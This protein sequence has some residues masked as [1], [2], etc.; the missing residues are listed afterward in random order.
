MSFPAQPAATQAC[1]CAQ[2]T[3]RTGPSCFL[4]QV[5]VLKVQGSSKDRDWSLTP[6]RGR[7]PSHL[8]DQPSAPHG[9]PLATYPLQQY[10]QQHPAD[11]N[12]LSVLPR[13]DHKTAWQRTQLGLYVVDRQLHQASNKQSHHDNTSVPLPRPEN[14]QRRRQ[15][16]Q[17]KQIVGV[18]SQ[19][20]SEFDVSLWSQNLGILNDLN[21]LGREQSQKDYDLSIPLREEILR[22]QMQEMMDEDIHGVGSRF[23]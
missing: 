1:V 23:H 19:F 18:G 2:Y 7:T 6:H 3:Y 11:E 9:P 17:A 13:A 5:E 21:S 16:P 8:D 4:A 22:Q 14:A 20:I 12:P 15:K 10:L